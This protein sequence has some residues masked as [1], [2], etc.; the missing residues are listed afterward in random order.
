MT[1]ATDLRDGDR[2]RFT[3]EGVVLKDGNELWLGPDSE[4]VIQLTSGPD[5]RN[6][7]AKI[8][9]LER[10]YD[11]GVYLVEEP[12]FTNALS[13]VI[14]HD[15]KWYKDL[16]RLQDGYGALDQ[17]FWETKK[18]VRFIGPVMPPQDVEKEYS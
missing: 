14:H 16:Y 2:I 13:L 18:I 10:K 9:V 11:N 3:I 7:S 1:K 5:I 6:P 4:P 12:G 17:S 15:G 8:E